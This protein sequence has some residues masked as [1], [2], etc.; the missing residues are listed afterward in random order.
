MTSRQ[1]F[2][3]G[4]DR[5]RALK[6]ADMSEPAEFWR[7]GHAQGMGQT[8]FLAGARRRA[9][10]E[11]GNGRGRMRLPYSAQLVG[12]PDTGVVHGGV[13]TALL[14]QA[15]GMAVGSAL[16]MPAMHRDARSAHRL[17][18]AAPPETDS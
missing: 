8:A 10:R 14:D 7:T 3:I 6:T 15:C 4:L 16:R 13:I 12:N 11:F 1:L 18:E 5:R 17:H 9:A 2:T